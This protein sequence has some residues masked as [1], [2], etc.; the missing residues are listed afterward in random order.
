MYTNFIN[1]VIDKAVKTPLVWR[2]NT[3]EMIGEEM[4]ISSR[5]QL[6]SS[7]IRSYWVNEARDE[8]KLAERWLRNLFIPEIWSFIKL[9]INLMTGSFA[10]NWMLFDNC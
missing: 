5:V 6:V 4:I 7:L 3:F 10:P 9:F 1:V 2:T 8:G